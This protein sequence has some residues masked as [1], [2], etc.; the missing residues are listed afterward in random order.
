VA[1]QHIRRGGAEYSEAFA[2]LLPRGPAWPRENESVLMRLVSGLAE[3]WGSRIDPR[4]A[5]LLERESDPSLTLELLSDWERVAGLPD[6]CLSEEL[7]IADRQAA[8]VAR[9]TMEGGQSIPF[10]TALALAI[11]YEI[12]II[13]HAPFMAGVS[14]VGDTRFNPYG[15]F[16]WEIGPEEI[17]FYWTVKIVNP[18]LSWFR[19]GSGQAGVDPHLRIGIASDLECVFRRFKPAHTELAFSYSGLAPIGAMAG[20]P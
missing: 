6:P 9:L 1:D 19:A 10:F 20:T 4:A 7:T 15:G 11:G 5:D 2:A 14:S 8:L 12:I 18:R 16:R 13:E 3:I 17:R